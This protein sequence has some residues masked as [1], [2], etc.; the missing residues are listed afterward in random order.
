VESYS[1]TTRRQFKCKACHAQYSP[2]SQTI[3]ANRKMSYME[4]IVA[5]AFLVAGVFDYV[6]LKLWGRIFV[7]R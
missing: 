4:R 1:I 2:I 6:M 7:G 3:L 5:I